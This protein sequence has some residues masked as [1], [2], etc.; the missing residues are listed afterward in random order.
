MNETKALSESM[1][2]AWDIVEERDMRIL[3]E[4]RRLL[5]AF[6]IELH[7]KLNDRWQ[8]SEQARCFWREVTDVP[9]QP[10]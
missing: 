3:M 1:H 6:L 10:E 7:G 8:F 5:E 9:A 4:K 2:L